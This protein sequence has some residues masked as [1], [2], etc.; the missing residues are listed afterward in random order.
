L[1]AVVLVFG[2]A[3][4]TALASDKLYRWVDERGQVVISDRPPQAGTP[5]ETLSVKSGRSLG[6]PAV[7]APAEDAPAASGSP[8][9]Q[10]DDIVANPE[11][12]RIARENLNALETAGR[13]KK[14]GDDGEPYF[15]TEEEKEI[16]RDR[17]RSLIRVH[18]RPG[19]SQET[20]E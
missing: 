14:I 2:Q 3:A 15:L 1:L 6:N 18:C 5:H 16:E 13:I 11:T 4:S 10:A 8:A 20:K 19:G 9:P 17:A 7:P 12:C